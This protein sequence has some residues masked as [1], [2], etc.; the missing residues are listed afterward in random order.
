MANSTSFRV[1]NM[2]SLYIMITWIIT[3]TKV[4]VLAAYYR[5]ETKEHLQ[6]L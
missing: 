3:A 5:D 1:M 6:T 4:I 2:G